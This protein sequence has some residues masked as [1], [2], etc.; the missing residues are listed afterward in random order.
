MTRST[1]SSFSRAATDSSKATEEALRASEARYRAAFETSQDGMVIFC[2]EDN[3]SLE[4]NP[5]LSRITGWSREELV[6]HT[7]WDLDL[8]VDAEEFTANREQLFRDGSILNFE[9]RMRRKGGEIIWSVWSALLLEVDGVRRGMLVIRDISAERKAEQARRGVEERYRAAFQTSFDGI[10]LLALDPETLDGVY[11]DA[12]ER[13]MEI[14]SLTREEFFGRSPL[15]IGLW[16]DRSALEERA[17]VLRR[18]GR[19]QDVEECFRRRDGELR[20]LLTSGAILEIEGRLCLLVTFRDITEARL[21]A[22]ALRASEARYRSAFETSQDGIA[23]LRHC[24]RTYLDV[25]AAF[26]RITG[27]DRDDL[28]AHS[29]HGHSLFTQ[30]SK[31]LELREA[32]AR[33]GHYEAGPLEMKG[34][35]G[36]TFWGSISASLMEIDGVSC[37]H[38]TLRDVTAE[39]TS[40]QARR[41]SEAR[42]RTAFE[43][44]QDAIA[45]FNQQDHTLLDV[46]EKFTRTFGWARDEVLGRTTLEVNLDVSQADR[47]RVLEELARE[48]VVGD[49]LIPLC[50]KS[51]EI[52]WAV[53]SG[54]R[55]DIDGVPC[56]YITVR[57]VTEQRR[58]EEERQA[59]EAR[60]RAAFETS[61][62]AI[63]IT[64]METETL[65]EANDQFL[66]MHGFT[67]DQVIGRQTSELA[68]WAD[69][70][71]NQ[72]LREL[73]LR[74]GKVKEQTVQ[75]RRSNGEL[76]W[77]ALS[78]SQVEINGRLCSM[79]MV[80]DITEQRHAEESLKAS[81]ARYRTIFQTSHDPISIVRA[82][83]G[84]FLDVSQ[85][86]LETTGWSRE[87]VIGHTT[88]EIGI[89]GD[90][91][92]RD[93]VISLLDA[94]EP[95]IN[96]Q[97]QFNK[98]NGES[99]WGMITCSRFEMEGET[100]TL[101]VI[102]DLTEARRAEAEIRNLSYFDPL[103]GLANR[104]QLYERLRESLELAEATGHYLG[105]FCIDI[106]NFQTAN[107]AFGHA[108]GDLIL[109]IVSQRIG[110]CVRS[111]D[112]VARAGSDEFFV[113][114]DHLDTNREAA[115][116][117]I[118]MIA[119]KIMTLVALPCRLDAREYSCTC[120]IGI[121]LTGT[122][123]CTIG[124]L[125]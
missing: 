99:L 59:S 89:W 104:R 80:S 113:L 93:K 98:K 111:T 44:S 26:L 97:A 75:L 85:V 63:A 60:Y 62:D 74:G 88:A 112:L 119:E 49:T 83:D 27:W 105:L 65:I 39:H 13:A 70:P 35:G 33:Q 36:M 58:A 124:E 103:T 9:M 14:S 42:Y 43:T 15:E 87:E 16:S 102:R 78:A 121:T 6:G 109:R 82:R 1:K 21:A 108:S 3:I 20:W 77:G 118:R 5:A 92:V 7:A 23:I 19:F 25:N 68:L 12:N 81:E 84:I 96:F 100:C 64:D 10:A 54:A 122:K 67:R 18:D 72:A 47:G 51:G 91:K 52:F 29:T 34:K 123:L 40:E 116:E 76:F 56:S 2:L 79:A 107:N 110:D 73:L 94:G 86:Y 117:Q 31:R 50:R 66:R 37:T 57:D 55:M 22:E 11:I 101:S 106:D 41:A 95:V 53:V 8:I 48:S 32:L 24:D 30:D 38:F 125:L 61:F 45:I 28:I 4:V 90:R 115:A 46:N 120:S 69:L 114:L 17:A 71:S